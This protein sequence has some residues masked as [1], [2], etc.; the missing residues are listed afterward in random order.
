MSATAGSM[1]TS[2]AFITTS[3]GGGIKTMIVLGLITLFAI[4]VLFWTYGSRFSPRINGKVKPPGRPIE[5]Y[6]TFKIE[7]D[8]AKWS[9][10][11]IVPPSIASSTSASP[12][13]CSGH[14][15]IRPNYD[16]SN[17]QY[18]CWFLSP[19][20]IYANGIITREETLEELQDTRWLLSARSLA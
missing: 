17:D 3:V 12:G 6:G 16:R 4:L 19:R 10:R 13:G 8:E 11:N 15:E 20:M 1:P 5:N 7:A 9:G 14:G 18:A 2:R